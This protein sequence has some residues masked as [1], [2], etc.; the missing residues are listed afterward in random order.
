MAAPPDSPGP[1]I[2]SHAWRLW[3]GFDVPVLLPEVVS[4]LLA[5]PPWQREEVRILRPPVVVYRL[6]GSVRGRRFLLIGVKEDGDRWSE[7]LSVI[8]L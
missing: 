8:P 6:K 7:V 3:E 4:A 2:S 5:L 1:R